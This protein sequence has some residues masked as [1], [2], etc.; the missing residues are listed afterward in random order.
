MEFTLLL[1]EIHFTYDVVHYLYEQNFL[2]YI[3]NDYLYIYIYD[4][5]YTKILTLPQK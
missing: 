1:Y 5:Y 4:F 2:I 3:N